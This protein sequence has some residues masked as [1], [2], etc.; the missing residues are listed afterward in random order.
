LGISNEWGTVLIIG[1]SNQLKKRGIY[2][3]LSWVFHGGEAA[4]SDTSWVF[5][6]QYGDMGTIMVYTVDGCEILHQ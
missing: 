1:D 5:N 6:Q 4:I 3:D 2:C